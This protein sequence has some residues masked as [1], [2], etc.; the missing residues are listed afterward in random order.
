MLNVRTAPRGSTER[1]QGRRHVIGAGSLQ[2][3]VQRG[4]SGNV[5]QLHTGTVRDRL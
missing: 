5:H 4:S 3:G 1:D 2:D